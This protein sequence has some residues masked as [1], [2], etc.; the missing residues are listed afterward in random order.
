MLAALAVVLSLLG[1][2]DEALAANS[3]AS[4]LYLSNTASA[5]VTGSW[6]LVTSAPSSA[7]TSTGNRIAQNATGYQDFGPASSRPGWRTARS[8]N[9]V[10]SA[11]RDGSSTLRW[12]EL[13]GRTWTFQAK[14]QVEL[15]QHRDGVPRCRHVGGEDRL[16]GDRHGLGETAD[17]TDVSV[18]APCATPAPVNFITAAGSTTVSASA[19]LL[20][21]SLAS[22]EH[23]YVQLWRNETV[24]INSSGT[25]QR[26]ATLTVNDGTASIAHP[27]ANAFPDVPAL[28]SVA[29]RVEH[30]SEPVGDV[31]RPG[32]F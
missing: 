20:G 24:G 6:Q 28:G 18:H 5:L 22:D 12:G 26:T 4:T 19:S 16:R 14:L 2:V 30:G 3:Y 15:E 23:L 1:R 25:G 27:T 11:T 9:A 21:F 8:S 7:D 17:L 32:R 31:L 10:R 13:P 29:A